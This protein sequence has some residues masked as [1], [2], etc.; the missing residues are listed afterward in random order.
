MYPFIIG[1]KSS[2]L[3][4]WEFHY[5]TASSHCVGIKEII[6]MSIQ[7]HPSTIQ[8]GV[9]SA[10]NQSTRITYAYQWEI[11][12][13]KPICIS[14]LKT[15]VATVLFFI[16]SLTQRSGQLSLVTKAVISIILT[17]TLELHTP[18]ANN[19]P[20]KLMIRWL[21]DT[22]LK[23]HKIRIAET[24]SEVR[25]PVTWHRAPGLQT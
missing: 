17:N 18:S 2:D 19:A 3:H 8:L 15:C 4:T 6:P 10:H 13:R 9:T 25:S 14:C 23:S 11:L 12:V 20:L 1:A 21:Y 16:T 24:E 5:N 7:R 22:L